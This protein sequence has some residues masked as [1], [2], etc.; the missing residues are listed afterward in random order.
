[1][2][3]DKRFL[4]I[5]H[6]IFSGEIV[7][8]GGADQIIEYLIGKGCPLTIA[9]H[10]L[11][12][13]S[14]ESR[15]TRDGQII[16][17]AR[18]NAPVPINWLREVIFNVTRLNKIG[19][20]YTFIL[21]GDPLCFVSAWLLKVLGLSSKIHFH[22]VDYS[23]RRFRN[24][25][26]NRVYKFLYRLAVKGS[27]TV[28]FVSYPM[29]EVIKG[30]LGERVFLAKADYLPNSPV[31]DKIPRINPELK[32]RYTLVVNSS[33]YSLLEVR[34]FIRQ[35]EEL[36]NKFPQVVLNIVGNLNEE[37]KNLIK[38]S[39]AAGN[40]SLHGLISYPENI[41]L[42]SEAYI[43]LAWYDNTRSFEKYADSLKIREY[44]AAGIPT[45][46]NRGISTAV[47]MEKVEAGLVV[48]KESDLAPAVCRLIGDP[49]FYLKLS[50]NAINWA[51]K[52]DKNILLESLSYKLLSLG[53]E[54]NQ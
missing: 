5:I 4:V 14:S 2:A 27:D 12:E 8:K 50:K 51:K 35:I 45:V 44:A 13:S 39:S 49:R 9:E 20:R 36:R 54:A 32:N 48:D 3:E 29:G 38:N 25:F 33:I 1:M 24:I 16:E 7:K 6:R 34:R 31:F 26:L 22:S 30:I 15:I 53:K 37:A 52:N 19:G 42:I 11:F 23:D 43:G 40:I 46:S 41:K 10:P 18:L 21:S 28:T 47:E 17:R